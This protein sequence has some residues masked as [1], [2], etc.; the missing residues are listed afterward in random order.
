MDQVCTFVR[1]LRRTAT[2]TAACPAIMSGFMLAPTVLFRN[3]HAIRRLTL[4]SEDF[5]ARLQAP[6]G[7]SGEHPF[8]GA[9]AGAMMVAL[10]DLRVLSQHLRQRVYGRSAESV[11]VHAAAQRATGRR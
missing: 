8:H 3:E 10:Q 1:G 5:T 7:L 11:W 6:A 4:L 9:S 2:R